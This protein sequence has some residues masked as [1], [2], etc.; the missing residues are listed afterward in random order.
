MAVKMVERR[1]DRS[2]SLDGAIA[3]SIADNVSF[4]DLTGVEPPSGWFLP[5][6]PCFLVVVIFDSGFFLSSDLGLPRAREK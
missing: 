3:N 1:L 2:C 6:L 5:P 4:D